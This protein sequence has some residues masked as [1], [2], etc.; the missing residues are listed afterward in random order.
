MASH[1]FF[2][3][4]EGPTVGDV[5]GETDAGALAHIR[6]DGTVQ[7][8]LQLMADTATPVLL[9]LSAPPPAVLGDVLGSVRGVELAELLASGAAAPTDPVGD[10]LAARPP[11]VGVNEP[12]EAARTALETTDAVLVLRDGKPVALLT[13]DDL[14]AHPS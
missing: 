9:V 12:L 8:A 10:H 14:A 7:E 2:A 5:L 11:L 3:A 4:E 1:G 6:P 13:R